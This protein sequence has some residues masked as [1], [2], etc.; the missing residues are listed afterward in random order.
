MIKMFHTRRNSSP[1]QTRPPPA[2]R[3]ILRKSGN[4]THSSTSH[5]NLSSSP[6]RSSSIEFNDA[7][8][9]WSELARDRRS[10]LS[11]ASPEDIENPATSIDSINISESPNH[12]TGDIRHVCTPPPPCDFQHPNAPSAATSDSVAS[13]S[14]GVPSAS[15]S[16]TSCAHLPPQPPPPPRSNS[17]SNSFH[18]TQPP[19]NHVNNI[20]NHTYMSTS[21]INI[22]AD[23]RTMTNTSTP[24]SSPSLGRQSFGDQ[25]PSPLNF[26]VDYAELT[27][28]KQK[29]NQ[30]DAEG[31]GFLSRSQFYELFSS[32][33]DSAD[34][35][36]HHTPMFNFAY[37]LFRSAGDRLNLREF[38]TGMSVLSKG[39]EEER[40][41]YLFT[42]YDI[43][44]SG[45]LNAPE[46]KQ[47]FRVMGSYAASHD[48][49]ASESLDSQSLSALRTINP[50]VLD[51]LVRKTV[52]QYDLDGDGQIGFE[53]FV[54]W[55]GSDP[56][57]KTWM[58]MLCYDTAKGVARLRG[59]SEKALIA[60][61]LEGLGIADNHFWRDSFNLQGNTSGLP[62]SAPPMS[63]VTGSSPSNPI[64]PPTLASASHPNVSTGMTERSDS[65]GE[66][67][68]DGRRRRGIH[69]SSLTSTPVGMA[70]S[71][72]GESMDGMSG[73]GHGYGRDGSSSNVAG[74]SSNNLV[75]RRSS[76]SRGMTETAIGT[77]EID[78]KTMLFEKQIGCGS[79]AVVW[80]CKWLDSPV[81]VK[82]FKSG[83]RLMLNSDGTPVVTPPVSQTTFSSNDRNRSHNGGVDCGSGGDR[84]YMID[85]DEEGQHDG[86]L[87]NGES[88]EP[89]YDSM[90]D[91]RN[92]DI[93][94]SIYEEDE[95]GTELATNRQR[96]LQEVSLLKSIRHPN[97]LL[98]MGACVDPS[99]PLCIVSELID[100]GSLFELL[101]GRDHVPLSTRQKLLLTQDIARGMLYLHGRDPI[102]L[103][104]D[105]KS[106]NILVE[107]QNDNSFKGTIIDFGLSKFSSTQASILPG[108][109]RGLTG[110][111]VTMAPEVMNEMKYEPRSDVYSYA[112]VCWEIWCGRIPFG[113]ITG[114]AQLLMKVAVQGGRPEFETRDAVPSGIQKLIR[115]CWD[116]D[117]RNRPDFLTVVK[118]L[119]EIRHDLRVD[120]D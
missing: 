9:R 100:G 18:P 3:A 25:S 77:F 62:N 33:M 65:S 104:R 111:L 83:P 98:Y 92:N 42:M 21:N 103:H 52:T 89:D 69:I 13:N 64:L 37:S 6:H 40:L 112:I 56:V 12:Q 68:S 78:F 36:P 59:E 76:R 20:T 90:M 72:S 28:L 63:S 116:Q 53:D 60:R 119:N 95:A 66:Y 85:D 71:P 107:L 55:C 88:F 39:S 94:R 109:G 29:F 102:V 11:I 5:S 31:K 19:P 118:T 7:R 115:A 45:S 101:H 4:T 50:S 105:L 54:K 23:V 24:P 2:P 96:F 114:A 74:N 58:D 97:L 51:D 32:I 57:V 99:Y 75:R 110:S 70:P 17:S 27:A 61:E 120:A 87:E 49:R 106:A 14:S 80:K 44:N 73:H 16:P 81:A 10:G 43:D 38:V 67:E 79:F 41:R 108:R 117:V 48:F 26:R 113:K 86:F 91:A 1:S 93:N 34:R 30:L 47:V 8:Q 15:P 82:V 46:L 35:N 84:G 22:N